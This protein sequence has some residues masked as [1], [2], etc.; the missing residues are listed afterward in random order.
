MSY[1]IGVILWFFVICHLDILHKIGAILQTV[2]Y[3]GMRIWGFFGQGIY[4]NNI[5]ETNKRQM[6]CLKDTR[7]PTCVRVC[8]C[9]CV[10]A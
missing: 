9:V 3:L 1:E 6:I 8:A 5:C 4:Q 10:R 7:V 2:I